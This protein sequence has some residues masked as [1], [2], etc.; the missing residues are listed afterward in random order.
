MFGVHQPTMDEQREALSQALMEV[1]ASIVQPLFDAA[2]GMRADLAR[3]GWSEAVVDHI[4]GAWL[5]AMLG[6]VGAA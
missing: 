4:V 2:D 3:R 6:K 1:R 5:A